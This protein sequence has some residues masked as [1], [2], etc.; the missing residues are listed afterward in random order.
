[1]VRYKNELEEVDRSQLKMQLHQPTAAERESLA[2]RGKYKRGSRPSL[3]LTP[4]DFF[5]SVIRS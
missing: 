3:L 4:E 2:V 1:M 5:V